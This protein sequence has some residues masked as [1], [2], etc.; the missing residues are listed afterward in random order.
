MPLLNR[1]A[2]C[3]LTVFVLAQG[4]PS[5]AAEDADVR[6]AIQENHAAIHSLNIA[7]IANIWS[8]GA[9]VTL[10]NPNDTS[11]SVG[12]DAVSDRW[13]DM[14]E[15]VDSLDIKQTEGPF[16]AVTGEVARAVGI[17]HATLKVISQPPIEV[18]FVETDVLVK[19][20]GKW[21]IVSHCAKPM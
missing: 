1:L 6:A 16:V 20:N 21:L 12:W 5:V 10:I 17:A 8:H 18:N 9:D 13:E 2:Y 19:K 14:I 15:H 4:S 11:V 7:V 3:S